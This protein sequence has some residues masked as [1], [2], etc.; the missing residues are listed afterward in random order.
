[1]LPM[2]AIANETGI[3]FISVKG[4]ELLNMVGVFALWL[5]CG[6]RQVQRLEALYRMLFC[7]STMHK[8]KLTVHLKPIRSGSHWNAVVLDK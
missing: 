4:P 6:C 5:P 7:V 2:Q 8:Q 3:N 1:M